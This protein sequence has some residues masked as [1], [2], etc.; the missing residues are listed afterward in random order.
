MR[1]RLK[2]R[3][4]NRPAAPAKLTRFKAR[5]SLGND[6]LRIRAGIIASGQPTLGWRELDR[7]LSLR[8]GEVAG[9]QM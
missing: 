3:K 1:P 6:L 7:E 2:T 5:T 8:R 4:R 9:E